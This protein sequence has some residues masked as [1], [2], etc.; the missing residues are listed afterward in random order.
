MNAIQMGME[1][2]RNN[3][4]I[5]IPNDRLNKNKT[6]HPES[7]FPEFYIPSGKGHEK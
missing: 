1:H 4:N 3:P 2:A 7:N 6:S 5:P